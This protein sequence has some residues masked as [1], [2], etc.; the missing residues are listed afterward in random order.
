MITYSHWF[1]F[2]M[3]LIPV[4]PLLCEVWKGLKKYRTSKSS[5]SKRSL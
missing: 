4:Y 5:N 2:A 3:L 1:V